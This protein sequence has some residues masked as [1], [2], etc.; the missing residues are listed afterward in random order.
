MLDLIR[1]FGP[2]SKSE[3]AERS[4]LAVSSVLNVVSSLSRRGLIRAT[5]LGP[6]TGGRP[7][8]L[9][10]LN[11]DAHYAVGA[12]VRI[13]LVE[14]VLVD[15]VGNVVGETTLRMEGVFDPGSTVDTIAEAVDQ[16]VRLAR[17]DS[18]RVLGAGVG[19]PGL[20]RGG[21]TVVAA[22]ALPAWRDVAFADQLEHILGLPTTVENDANLGAL[23]EYRHGVG[24]QNG[25]WRSLVY[26]YVD[27][28][29]GG[30]M[31]VDGRLYRGSDGLAGELGHAIVDVDG[32]QC[33]CGTYGC[34]EAM[35][36][37]GS[38][39]RRVTSAGKLGAATTLGERFGENWDAVTYEAVMEALNDGDQVA[40]GA[41]DEAIAC[42]AIGV[43]NID[44]LL[45]PEAIVLGGQLFDRTPHIFER[46]RDL[47]LHRP[48]FFASPPAH[49]AVG[50]LNTRAPCVGAAALVLENFFG[51][52]ERVMAGDSAWHAP[53]PSFEDALV[54]PQLAERGI[55]FTRGN[56]R[57]TWAGNLQP[58]SLRVRNGDPITVT[59]EV[60]RTGS[61]GGTE[62]GL[63]V[64]LHWDRVP[65]FGGN[66]PNPKNSPMQ[67][68]QTRGRRATYSVT[69]GMLPPGKY[70]FAAHVVGVNDMWVRTEGPGEV[71]G[72]V[73]VL[74]SRVLS[75]EGERE[76]QPSERLRKE[77]SAATPL[78]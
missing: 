61:A 47:V 57:V 59:V 2:L 56:E 33:V 26:I 74:P 30:G 49:L 52:P 62:P 43:S 54:W 75:I 8:T 36:S 55:L 70:E 53:E 58:V 68:V 28:G 64:L 42:L 10:E 73:E 27:H 22:P 23:A 20:V 63:K 67:H 4:G 51:V 48:S 29:I 11:P 66:W 77:G 50:D 13:G 78:P 35:A 21:R 38:I 34:L 9:L 32:P 19:F 3:L 7:P 65:M 1:R 45:R 39:V 31:V 41:I 60:E 12:N 15:L 5:G 25:G 46:L 14:A 71:N 76:E 6:S 37:I 72:R 16:V 18:A 69:L 44:R 40:D 17:I 24:A